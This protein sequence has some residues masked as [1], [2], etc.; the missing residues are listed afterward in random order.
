MAQRFAVEGFNEIAPLT[1]AGADISNMG[2]K[3]FE[4]A[5]PDVSL[6]KPSIS[7]G[8]PGGMA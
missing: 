5:K 1:G 7:I 8:G 6:A 3:G 2:M 4:A